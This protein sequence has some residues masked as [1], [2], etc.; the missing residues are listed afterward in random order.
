MHEALVEV[1]LLRGRI[2]PHELQLLVRL[3]V[4]AGPDVRDPALVR[5]SRHP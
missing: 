4:P 2:P 3:E 1:A 5:V